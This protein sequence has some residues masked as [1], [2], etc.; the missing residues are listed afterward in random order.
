MNETSV[1]YWHEHD[2]PAYQTLQQTRDLWG[3]TKP[4][5]ATF[6]KGSK[7]CIQYFNSLKASSIVKFSLH[8][9]QILGKTESGKS[10]LIHTLKWQ[11]PHLVDPLDRTVVDDTVD[12]ELDNLQLQVTDFGNWLV[13][14][15]LERVMSS[16]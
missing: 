12:I 9:V 3:L 16:L 15:F 13:P 4:P 14:Y 8:S 7:A 11:K 6:Q 1:T 5:F 10:S 2:P